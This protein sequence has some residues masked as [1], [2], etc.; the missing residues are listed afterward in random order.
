MFLIFVENHNKQLRSLTHGEERGTAGGEGQGKVIL[1]SRPYMQTTF[2]RPPA[3]AGCRW[4]KR[5]WF[6]HEKRFR[7]P[8][9]N[10]VTPAVARTFDSQPKLVP[11]YRPRNDERLG[12]PEP[13][14]VDNLLQDVMFGRRTH[15]DES[16]TSLT[17]APLEAR[18]LSPCIGIQNDLRYYM[19]HTVFKLM[20]NI[21]SSFIN[22][23][24][25]HAICGHRPSMMWSR[26]YFQTETRLV[27]FDT[28]PS[29]D[30]KNLEAETFKFRFRAA[31]FFWNKTMRLHAKNSVNEG[32]CN[33]C[34]LI[35]F[36]HFL[37]FCNY[38]AKNLDYVA[39]V[40]LIFGFDYSL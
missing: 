9:V 32:I 31:T 5:R 36:V 37:H 8:I 7:Q 10:T 4:C 35:D 15:N 25:V 16:R 24:H 6:S 19:R 38:T 18:K 21:I 13:M 29:R 40:K 3:V 17:N 27:A 20:F 14:R 34:W 39:Y 26:L 2:H 12:W 11:I 33:L 30:L 23:H 1:F 28:E 22:V